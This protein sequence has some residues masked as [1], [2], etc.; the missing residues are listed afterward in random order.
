MN[1]FELTDMIWVH[2]LVAFFN[3]KVLNMRR[4]K[5]RKHIHK[6]LRYT[7]DGVFF[8]FLFFFLNS[9]LHVPGNLL[10][11]SQRKKTNLNLKDVLLH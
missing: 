4:K 9:A 6:E 8:S 3:L 5:R 11:F 7:T 10:K 1:V 2:D